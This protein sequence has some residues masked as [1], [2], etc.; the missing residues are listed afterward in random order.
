[1]HFS[2]TND[3]ID[4]FKILRMHHYIPETGVLYR[5]HLW[6]NIKTLARELVVEKG[7]PMVEAKR[8]WIREFVINWSEIKKLK[9]NNNKE[10][11]NNGDG[12]LTI[13]FIY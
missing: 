1:M 2:D 9:P 11:I 5:W 13:G 4:S 12:S 8:G 3:Q 7:Q 6:G 10:S